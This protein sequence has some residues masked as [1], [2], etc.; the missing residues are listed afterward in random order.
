MNYI[1][2]PDAFDTSLL[3]KRWRAVCSL[4]TTMKASPAFLQFIIGIG[5]WHWMLLIVALATLKMN[6]MQIVT[7]FV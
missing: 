2:D 5:E 4:W 6:D 7:G 3:K 1:P